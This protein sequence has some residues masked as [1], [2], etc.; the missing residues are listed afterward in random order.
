MALCA[1]D[2]DRLWL[3]SVAGAVV[4]SPVRAAGNGAVSVGLSGTVNRSDG[5]GCVRSVHPGRHTAEAL[6]ALQQLHLFAREF[7]AGSRPASG[8][9]LAAKSAS[10][11]RRRQRAL[12][13]G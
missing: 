3:S 13:M 12:K 9:I 6:S 8:C 11:S 1:A 5:G 7:P 4:D 2:Y 10:C